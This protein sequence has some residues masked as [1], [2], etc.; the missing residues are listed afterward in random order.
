MDGARLRA[1]A[2]FHQPRRSITARAPQ[3]ATLPAGVGIVDPPVEALGIEAHRIRNAQHDHLAVLQGDKAVVQVGSRHGHI[4][5][6]TKGVVLIDPG[7]IARL[8]A[9]LLALEARARI[10]MKRPTLRAMIARSLRA[11]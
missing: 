5:T 3:T 6:E 1:F 4:L 2:A 7:V 9:R 11:V 10:A 8:R